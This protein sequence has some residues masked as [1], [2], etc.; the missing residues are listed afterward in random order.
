MIKISLT[1]ITHAPSFH[2]ND[3]ICHDVYPRDW[4]HSN[5]HVELSKFELSS[6]KNLS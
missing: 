5:G 2:V 6:S 4:A 3:S 1:Q